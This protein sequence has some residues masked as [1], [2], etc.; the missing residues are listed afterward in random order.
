MTP[1]RVI[2]VSRALKFLGASRV[3]RY[4]TG[5]G[6]E[7]RQQKTTTC[8]VILVCGELKFLGVL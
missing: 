7:V 5:A 1:C 3:V 4:R 2:L 8:R 6:E